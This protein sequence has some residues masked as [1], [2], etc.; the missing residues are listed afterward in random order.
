[1]NASLVTSYGPFCCCCC[2]CCCYLE[3]S[4]CHY[5]VTA[6]ATR[7]LPLV[8]IPNPCRI[9]F[10]TATRT[11]KSL[12]MPPAPFVLGRPGARVRVLQLS[13][14]MR[15]AP[16]R[17]A[18]IYRKTAIGSCFWGVRQIRFRF[19]M[20]ITVLRFGVVDGENRAHDC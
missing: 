8:S 14:N 13:R 19:N 7:F 11:D 1:M 15:H 12:L 17:C 18:D 10:K 9:S 20:E 2:C 4:T 5:C 16:T 6:D 3:F